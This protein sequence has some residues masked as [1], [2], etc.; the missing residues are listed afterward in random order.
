METRRESAAPGAEKKILFVEDEMCLQKVYKDF[1]RKRGFRLIPAY[2]GETALKLAGEEIPDLI[3]LDII[4]PK[5]DG[6]EVLKELKENPRLA[7]VP[8]IVITNLE[9]AE[10][11]ERAVS[12]GARAYLVKANYSLKEIIEKIRETV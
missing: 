8:V 2:D 5:K 10:H 9:G 11:V 6:F 1:F 3:L 12:L 4:L 7:K